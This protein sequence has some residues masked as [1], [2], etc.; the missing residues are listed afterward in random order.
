MS[1]L[2]NKLKISLKITGAIVFVHLSN[3]ILCCKN[4][5]KNLVVDNLQF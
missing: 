1:K 4:F 3:L 5:N 2:E